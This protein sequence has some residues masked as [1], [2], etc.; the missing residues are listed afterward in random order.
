MPSDLKNPHLAV[1]AEHSST[2]IFKAVNNG[3]ERECRCVIML[4]NIT[5]HH[6]PHAHSLDEFHSPAAE[7]KR[8]LPD[9]FGGEMNTYNYAGTINLCPDG[10]SFEEHEYAVTAR[11]S[12][13]EIVCLRLYTGYVSMESVV[14]AQPCFLVV[15]ANTRARKDD[16]DRA[17]SDKVA[18]S[19]HFLFASDP[20]QCT[21]CTTEK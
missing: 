20:G 15:S 9:G 12:K 21:N 14:F 3:E 5:S 4:C 11:L 13:L 8:V 10:K 2:E 16:H 6:K 19:L 1:E 7:W 18:N 17:P